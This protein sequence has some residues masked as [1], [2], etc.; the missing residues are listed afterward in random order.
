MLGK[1]QTTEDTATRTYL[2]G[3]GR[4]DVLLAVSHCQSLSTTMDA[5]RPLVAL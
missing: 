2:I 3:Y 5:Q 1:S 4:F